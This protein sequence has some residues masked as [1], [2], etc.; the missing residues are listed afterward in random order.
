MEFGHERLD[1]Y[2]TALDFLEFIDSLSRQGDAVARC[3]DAGQART[4]PGD[5]S[6]HRF[7]GRGTGTG[8]FHL[9]PRGH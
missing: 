2:Q 6:N 4:K 9:F 5:A 8:S 1:V 7:S 3:S